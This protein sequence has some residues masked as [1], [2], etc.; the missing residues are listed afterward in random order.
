[1]FLKFYCSYSALISLLCVVCNC[2]L[3]IY[4]YFRPNLLFFSFLIILYIFNIIRSLVLYYYLIDYL[5]YIPDKNLYNRVSPSGRI[6]LL[7]IFI[8]IFFLVVL[9]LNFLSSLPFFLSFFL[10]LLYPPLYMFFAPLASRPLIL[11]ILILYCQGLPLYYL[12]L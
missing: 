2:N 8:F 10:S 7:F 4:P 12:F 9:I 6:I 3:I 5:K 11:A 1:M